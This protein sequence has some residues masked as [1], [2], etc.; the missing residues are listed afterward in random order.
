MS[1]WGPVP[2]F[3][4]ALGPP[5]RFPRPWKHQRPASAGKP[6]LQTKWQLDGITRQKFAAWPHRVPNTTSFKAFRERTYEMRLRSLASRFKGQSC[7]CGT[8]VMRTVSAYKGTL[9]IKFFDLSWTCRRAGPDRT[10]LESPGVPGKK[11]EPEKLRK[12]RSNTPIA[13]IASFH[14][15]CHPIRIRLPYSATATPSTLESDLSIQTASGHNHAKR[16]QHGR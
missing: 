6:D 4:P 10:P 13:P 16:P 15:A 11:G 1:F 8:R 12:S 9:N 2:R 14:F 3:G 5:V 7:G